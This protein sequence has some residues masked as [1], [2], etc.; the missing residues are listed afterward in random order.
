MPAVRYHNDTTNSGEMF[1]RA[2]AE[3]FA[4]PNAMVVLPGVEIELEK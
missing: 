1:D 3:R 4:A 2:A